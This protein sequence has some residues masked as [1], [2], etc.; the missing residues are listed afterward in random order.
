MIVSRKGLHFDY[1]GGGCNA[2]WSDIFRLHR[3]RNVVFFIKHLFMGIR[4]ERGG[5]EKEHG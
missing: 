5:K 1:E 4:S 3:N 2:F